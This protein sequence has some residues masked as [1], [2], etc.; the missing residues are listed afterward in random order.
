MQLVKLGDPIGLLFSVVGMH[1]VVA[2]IDPD[3][4]VS[5]VVGNFR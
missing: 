2:R 3:W 1:A 5:D 4:A